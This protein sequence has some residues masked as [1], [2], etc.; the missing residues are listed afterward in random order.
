MEIR[1]RKSV[2][3]T[4][5]VRKGE[6]S[7]PA[8]VAGEAAVGAPQDVVAIS[9]IPETELT[10]NVRRALTAL[11]AEVQQLRRELVDARSRIGHLEKLVDEDPLIPVV[12]RRA[13]VR[14]LSRMMAFA[15][16]YGVPASVV[17]FDVNNMKKIN[18][19]H[20]HAAGDAALVA[21]SKVLLENVRAT[22]VVGRLGGDELGVLLVQT[23]Q[24]LAEHKA[25]E[26]AAL[27]QAQDMVWEG[28]PFHLSVA[29]G[30]HAF[31][32]GASPGE[33]LDAAD[34]AMYRKKGVLKGAE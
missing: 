32:P 31:S 29:W 11:M 13:F 24:A 18:D 10:P 6:V 21:I 9:G 2:Q 8:A 33:I 30:A 23:D 22:D 1:D 14:E 16:R 17:Y 15:Q 5:S 27:I 28:K 12:N 7:Q 25:G 34:R 19:A 4:S 3:R 20:G 26:L